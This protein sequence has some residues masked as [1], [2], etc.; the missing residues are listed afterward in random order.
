MPG[1][2]R[3]VTTDSTDATDLS[4]AANGAAS[5]ASLSKAWRDG[6]TLA[7]QS[8][9]LQTEASAVIHI[10]SIRVIG[11][12]SFSVGSCWVLIHKRIGII[13][14]SMKPCFRKNA[15]A[16]FS[17]RSVSSVIRRKFFFLA[18]S[19]ACSRSLLP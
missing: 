17:G 15:C 5:S 13:E 10:H 2:A 18:K 14:E 11:G 9:A 12:Y 16:T 8:S 1:S 19:I 7:S 6:R 4:D 3:K